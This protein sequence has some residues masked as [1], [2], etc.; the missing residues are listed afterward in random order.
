MTGEM[1]NEDDGNQRKSEKKLEYG[2]APAKS[3]EGAALQGQQ[4]K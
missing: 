4:Q 3:L 1:I 2:H